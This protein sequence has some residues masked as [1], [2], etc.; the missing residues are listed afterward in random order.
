MRSSDGRCPPGHE[1]VDGYVKS[2]GIRVRGYCR[3]RH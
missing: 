1:Y 2:G 3:D